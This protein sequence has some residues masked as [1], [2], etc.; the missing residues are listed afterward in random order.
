MAKGSLGTFPGHCAFSVIQ[1]VKTEII[2][3]VKEPEL[4]PA[5]LASLSKQL[6]DRKRKVNAG[7]NGAAR[8]EDAASL[9]F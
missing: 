3:R 6:Q 7:Q 9:P 4:T 5:G 8:P 1:R 2:L